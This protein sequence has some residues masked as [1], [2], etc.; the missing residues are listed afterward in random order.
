MTADSVRAVW[1]A[2]HDNGWQTYVIQNADG[3]FSAWTAPEG[4]TPNV[5]YI[6]M[7]PET[8]KATA[9]FALS[10]KGGQHACSAACSGGERH[11]HIEHE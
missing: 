7:D 9:M 1:M 8:V 11:T 6:E 10:K 2:R 5:D 3:T 4:Q